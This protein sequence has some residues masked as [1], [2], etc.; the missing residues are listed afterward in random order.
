[1]CPHHSE[2]LQGHAGVEATPC[3]EPRPDI[4]QIDQYASGVSRFFCHVLT[5]GYGARYA[6]FLKDAGIG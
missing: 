6:G 3:I 4:V 1:M 2:G 5:I